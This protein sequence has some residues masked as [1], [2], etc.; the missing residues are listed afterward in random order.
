[1]FRRTGPRF[2]AFA[3][4]IVLAAVITGLAQVPWWGI[5]AA[6]LAVLIPATI[7]E[8]WYARDRAV[9]LRPAPPVPPPLE[10]LHE[11]VRVIVAPQPEAP[12]PAPVEM[13]EPEPVI[14][15]APQEPVHA[16]P[17]N[18]WELEQRVKAHGADDDERGFLLLYLRDYAGPDGDL[19]A[20]FDALVRESF[21]DVIGAPAA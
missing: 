19:P 2:V 16:G 5:I 8:N 17:W 15:H 1:M 9:T 12:A 7:F 6:V 14:V 4:L 11:H 18:L 20:E 10:P 3:V 21:G 13:P